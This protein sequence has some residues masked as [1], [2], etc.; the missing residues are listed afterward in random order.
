[1]IRLYRIGYTQKS[2]E[3]FFG[4]IAENE[5]DCLVD[6]RQNP[7]GQLGRFTFE[8]DLPYFLDRLCNGCSYS[9]RVDLA[10]TKELL[11]KVRDKTEAMHKNYRIFEVAFRRHLDQASSVDDFAEAYRNHLRVVLLCSEPTI[12]KCHRRLV[13]DRLLELFPDKIEAGGH[14]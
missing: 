11:R 12:E 1:M 4:L 6:I 10:P 13:Y 14:L 7:R 5:I 3:T 8:Q 9:H 2:A